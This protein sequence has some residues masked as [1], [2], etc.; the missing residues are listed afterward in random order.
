MIQL[1]VGCK[2]FYSKFFE[3][4]SGVQDLIFSNSFD[5]S[6]K[7]NIHWKRKWFANTMQKMAREMML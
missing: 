3:D 2:A 6:L 1:I 4:E 5:Q 7:L